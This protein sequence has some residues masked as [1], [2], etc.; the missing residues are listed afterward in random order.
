MVHVLTDYMGRAIRLT[1]ERLDHILIH[2][3]MEG[4]HAFLEKALKRPEIVV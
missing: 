1:N 2:P 4:I 3:E